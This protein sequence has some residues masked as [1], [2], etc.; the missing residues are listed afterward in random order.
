[1]SVE[2]APLPPGARAPAEVRSFAASDGRRLR[3]WSVAAAPE[4][5]RI[6]YVHGIESHGTWFLPAAAALRERGCTTFLLDR[7]GSGL[8]R[9]PSPGE[10]VSPATLLD[11]L[12]GFREAIGDPPMHLAGLSWG[13]KL[14]CAAALDQPRG[15]RTLAL[16][17]PGLCSLVDLR[18]GAK[19]AM[20]AGL[21]L[22]RGRN[23]IRVPIEPEM[24]T[25]TPALLDFIR[26]DP[27]RT[28]HV[29]ARLLWS[30]TRLDRKVRRGIAALELPVLLVLAGRERIVDNAAVL[31]LLQQL[32]PG[33]LSVR[34]YAEATH[35]VQLEQ[36]G[37]LAGDMAAHFDGAC[38]GC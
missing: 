22:R 12:R 7:R 1:L 24:F 3:Y 5:H 27:W 30:G 13:G 34:T 23:R 15:L 29:S 33:R 37:R 20:A 8:N 17:T 10:A 35:S 26:N 11:D 4:R 21:V 16:I 28:K 32:P 31:A 6:L 14:A 2:T 18:P 38:P 36:T 19:L 25:T 9:E